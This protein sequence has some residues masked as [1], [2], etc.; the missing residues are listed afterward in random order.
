MH[1]RSYYAFATGVLLVAGFMYSAIATGREYRA[2]FSAAGAGGPAAAVDAYFEPVALESGEQLRQAVKRANWEQTAEISLV[3][4]ASF[5]PPQRDQLLMA[6][7][8]LLYPARVSLRSP[9]NVVADQARGRSPRAIVAGASNPFSSGTV[10][11]VSRTL[12]LV[13][14]R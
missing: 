7:S 2:V 13:D 14:L 10:Y 11:E 4:D 6:S 12:R 9:E 3:I 8:Y 1:S 5:A